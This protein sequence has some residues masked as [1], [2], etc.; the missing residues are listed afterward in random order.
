[1]GGRIFYQTGGG[2]P[3]RLGVL[4]PRGPGGRITIASP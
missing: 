1:M 4:K 3:C 2:L